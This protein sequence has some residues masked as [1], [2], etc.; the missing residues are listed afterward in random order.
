MD[1]FCTFS[2]HLKDLVNLVRDPLFVAE[3]DLLKDLTFSSMDMIFQSTFSR[4][5]ILISFIYRSCRDAGLNVHQR[6]VL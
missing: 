5:T 6:R 2:S 1:M 4:R 3:K